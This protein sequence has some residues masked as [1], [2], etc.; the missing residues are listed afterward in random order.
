MLNHDNRPTLSRH[1]TLTGREIRVEITA[2]QSD[3]NTWKRVHLAVREI[4]DQGS[5]GSA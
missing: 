3:H 5:V 2:A 4:P 1:H